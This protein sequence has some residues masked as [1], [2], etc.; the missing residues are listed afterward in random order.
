MKP[1]NSPPR[2][3]KKALR[4]LDAALGNCMITGKEDWLDSTWSEFLAATRW[5]TAVEAY[6]FKRRRSAL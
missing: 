1:K 4:G 2:L 5:L 3:T 6:R